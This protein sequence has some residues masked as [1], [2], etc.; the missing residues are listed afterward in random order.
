MMTLSRVYGFWKFV[1]HFERSETRRY[2]D[3][4]YGLQ[5]RPRAGMV[6]S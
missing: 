4:L 3:A 1:T 6:T 2:L 5:L